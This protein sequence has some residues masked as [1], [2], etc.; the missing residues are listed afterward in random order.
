MYQRENFISTC[1]LQ[2]LFRV[3]LLFFTCSI[4]LTSGRSK[5]GELP[6]S[7][8]DSGA[9][10]SL[11]PSPPGSRMVLP[12]V[13]RIF[14]I[15][16]RP[17]SSLVPIRL[18]QTFGLSLF[19]WS[20]TASSAGRPLSRSG[21][22]PSF[23]RSDL[24]SWPAAPDSLSRV[25]RLK[26]WMLTALLLLAVQSWILTPRRMEFHSLL[27]SPV[28]LW[29]HNT[30]GSS[31]SQHRFFLFRFRLRLFTRTLFVASVIPLACG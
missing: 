29:A 23:P 22:T 5:F 28:V 2:F 10:T 15:S 18:G 19:C 1:E 4:S 20:K 7:S 16:E 31:S 6:S 13:L 21:R 25:P 27:P 3:Q 24:G 14:H 9:D 30:F 26:S 8:Q 12:I 17:G 11:C